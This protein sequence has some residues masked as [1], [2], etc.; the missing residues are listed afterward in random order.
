M[1]EGRSKEPSIMIG[2]YTYHDRDIDVKTFYFYTRLMP[3]R[4]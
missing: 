1:I 4:L 3:H 2:L